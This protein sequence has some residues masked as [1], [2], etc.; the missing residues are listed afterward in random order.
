MKGWI[1]AAT[2]LAAQSAC[3]ADMRDTSYRDQYGHR[4]QQLVVVVKAPV[5]KVWDAFFTDEGFASWAAPVAHVTLENGGGMIEASYSLKSKIGDPEN[6]RNEIVA[7]L[8]LHML[9][10]RN[11]HVPKGAPF[12]PVLIRTIRTIVMF[13]DLGDGTTRVTESQVGYGDGAGY[14]SL[15]RHFSDGNAEEFAALADR[16]AKGPV[17]WKAQAAVAEVSV[18]KGDTK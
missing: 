18:H 11:A 17:D 14:D 6:I 13:D 10:F 15:Y 9:A 1:L 12:D 16:F 5:A 3:A 4:V 7:Y 8:P 2:L